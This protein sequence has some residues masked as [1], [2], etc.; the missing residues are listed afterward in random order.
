MKKATIIFLFLAL[1]FGSS[2]LLYGNNNYWGINIPIIDGAMNIQ[3]EKSDKM[4]TI[5]KSYD[6]N[7]DSIENIAKFYNDFFYSIGWEDPIMGDQNKNNEF[8]WSSHRMTFTADDKP[9]ATYSNMWKAKNIPAKGLLQLTLTDYNEKGFKGTVKV[10]L[11]PNID[12]SP[13]IKINQIIGKDPK[14]LFKLYKAIGENPFK[15]ENIEVPSSLKKEEQIV[16]QYFELI[17]NIL[18]S[19]DDFREKYVT[20]DIGSPGSVPDN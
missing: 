13:L 2:N 16:K 3:S 5:Y 12:T 6:I 15:I 4:L 18:E 17:Q 14:N 7:I 8:E 11:S 19:Y 9:E 1:S 10:I 20:Q